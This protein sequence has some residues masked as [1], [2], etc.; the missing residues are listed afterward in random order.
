MTPSQHL[1]AHLIGQPGSRARLNT[2]ALIID[3]DALEANI[4]AMAAFGRAAGVALRPHAKTHKSGDIGRMQVA[5][6]AVGLCCAKLGEAET[7]A[8]EGIESILLTSPVVTAPAIERLVALA[9][10][11]RD[12]AVVADHRDAVAALAGANDGKPICVLVDIDPGT[13]RTGVASAADAVALAR[14]IADAP[15][16]TYSGV[17][18]YCGSQQHIPSFADRRA[19]IADRTAYLQTVIAVL[20]EAGL[21]PP[22][23]TGGGTGTHRIDAE[24]GVLTE[25]QVGSYVFMD[26]EY[27]ECDLGT[28]FATALMVDTRVISANAGGMATLDAGLKAFATEAGM[29]VIMAG[30]PAGSSYRFM[31]DEHGAVV[32]PDGEAAPALGAR[33]T[34]MTPHCDPTV[35]LYDAYHVVR[36]DTLVAIWPVTARGRSA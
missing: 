9:G 25:L 32:V 20:T 36:G 2:P 7:M 10:R 4:A 19:A 8:A 33:L 13:H 28:S 22:V 18:F 26:R 5:A 1:H 34:A 21:A 11:M 3:L 15:Q 16:L 27:D 17:Q 24:L 30:A 14:Q 23:V 12:L 31:G 29:P 6:G 35:N